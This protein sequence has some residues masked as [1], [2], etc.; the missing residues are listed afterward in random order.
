M[1]KNSAL[2]NI[3]Q[4]AK[5]ELE[6]SKKKAYHIKLICTSVLLGY[7]EIRLLE[8]INIALEPL[9]D[10]NQ[11]RWIDLSH[12]YIETLSADFQHF[13]VLRTLYL[14]RNYINSFN[15]LEQLKGLPELKT[16]TVHGNPISEV[17]NFRILAISILGDLKKLD[18]V[19]ISRRKGTTHISSENKQKSTQLLRT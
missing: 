9:V 16:F 4:K 1:A 10:L 7:N 19:L 15:E 5:E 11:V 13:P 2:K 8:G 6:K 14:H 18:S 12:N 3:S 17:P